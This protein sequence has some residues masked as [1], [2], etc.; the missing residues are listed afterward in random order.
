MIDDIM[1]GMILKYTE[2]KQYRYTAVAGILTKYKYAMHSSGIFRVLISSITILN[3]ITN[4]RTMLT[5]Y[6]V[7][8][9]RSVC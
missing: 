2:K 1:I 3:P 6:V 4:D 8:N 5:M 7:L 9:N